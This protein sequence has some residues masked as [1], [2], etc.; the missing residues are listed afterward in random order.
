MVQLLTERALEVAA[1]RLPVELLEDHLDKPEHLMA[2][3]HW[4]MVACSNRSD[5]VSK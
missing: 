1:Y 4:A 3:F 5:F 2:S